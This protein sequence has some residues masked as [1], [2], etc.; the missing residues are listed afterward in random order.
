MDMTIDQTLLKK[1]MKKMLTM[2]RDYD[3]KIPPSFVCVKIR[4]FSVKIY[5]HK[6]D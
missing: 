6:K 2:V 4:L 5:S 3:N 1:D